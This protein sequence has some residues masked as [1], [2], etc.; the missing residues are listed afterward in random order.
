VVSLARTAC[1]HRRRAALLA[2]SIFLLVFAATA[3]AAP[4]VTVTPFSQVV[5]GNI[6]ASTS[7]VGV[8][9]SLLRSGTTVDT[10]TAT[11]TAGAWT[12]TFPSR[13][14]SN[15]DELDVSYTGAGAPTPTSSAY[16]QPGFAGSSV[17]SS[18]GST[19]TIAC[20][21]TTPTCGASVPVTVHYAG[22][23]TSSFSATPDVA[24]NYEA[25]LSPVVTANDLVTYSP[26]IAY[27]D[28]SDL[29][30]LLTAALPGVGDTDE[31]GYAAPTCAADLGDDYVDCSDLLNGY[32]F[33]SASYTLQQTRGGST[34]SSETV[35]PTGYDQFDAGDPGFVDATVAG[36][37]AG[38]DINLIVP[39]AGSK[40]ARTLTTLHVYPIR[41][42]VVDYDAHLDQGT[43]SGT[44]QPGEFDTDN[45]ILCSSGGSFSSFGEDHSFGF[46]DELSGGSTDLSIPSFQDESPA[47]NELVPTSFSAYADVLS[48]YGYGF[49]T[50][51]SVALSMTPLAGGSTRNFGGN[52][53]STSGVAVSGLAPGRWAADWTSTDPHGDTDSFT[54]WVVVEASEQGTQ[55]AQGAAG[56]PGSAGAG[57]PGATGPRG[58]QGP[59]GASVEVKCV[60]KTTGK[61][62]HKKTSQVCKVTQLPVGSRVN[63]S[64]RRGRVVYA[65][66]HGRIRGHAATVPLRALR[67]TPK[68]HYMLTIVVENGAKSLTIS[69]LVSL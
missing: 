49:D 14:V 27:Y 61:G 29:T 65:L 22:G 40:P 53:N 20:D 42:D 6:G 2:S 30:D 24:G 13:A 46:E 34:I 16:S 11:T 48:A 28:G 47:D 67:R 41:A 50:A 68:G 62:K 44:C 39:A 58:P 7:G 55:G 45:Y 36:L 31:F 18:D 10:T 9:L 8:H 15:T 66:G 12:A 5:S 3:S 64:L 32:F 1:L 59:A 17:I 51:S 25:T 57:T 56:S 60:S 37:Q 21:S 23:G 38:D 26:T 43:T 35:A 69:R 54:T 52:A 33:P 63:A 4:T 19:M